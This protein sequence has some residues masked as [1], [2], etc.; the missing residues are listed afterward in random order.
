[1][2]TSGARAEKMSDLPLSRSGGARKPL[3]VAV[4]G[5]WNWL[6]V[7]AELFRRA[8]I[9]CEVVDLR[10]R[11]ALLKWILS[12]RWRRFDVVHHIGGMNRFL[13][14]IFVAL[15]KP[16]VWHWIGTDFLK[17]GPIFRRGGGLRGAVS[18]RVV[19]QWAHRHLADSPEL[20]QELRSCG[21]RADVVR[22]LPE[23]IEAQVEPL[24]KIPCVLSY[25]NLISRNFYSAPLI[26]ELA[27]AF[28]EI[29]F[30]IV[31]DNGEGMPAP[32]NVQFLGRL[33]NLA[34]IYS[35]ASVYIRLPEHDSLSAMVLEMLARGRYVIYNKGL[36]GC[37]LAG[38][39]PG[40]RRALKAIVDLKEPNIEG[41]RFVK[42]TFSLDKEAKALAIAFEEMRPTR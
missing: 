22:L 2:P 4:M 28:P 17:Y 37:H 33:P 21:V 34:D 40:T 36:T 14:M 7:A 39:F 19:R 26:M 38:D 3:H 10:T 12:G 41:A 24:P 6:D 42:E 25:W 23:A 20:A 11:K 32:K 31:G 5:T 35:R 18:R 29:P 15:G 13:G 27:A 1:M 8:G 30:L 9:A 16:V